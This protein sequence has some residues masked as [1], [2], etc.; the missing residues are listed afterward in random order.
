MKYHFRAKISGRL[1]TIQPSNGS[2]KTNRKRARV[3]VK[4]SQGG[5][6]M[7]YGNSNGKK[8]VKRGWNGTGGGK[9]EEGGD[10]IGSNGCPTGIFGKKMHLKSKKKKRQ[11]K[12]CRDT[13]KKN[14]RKRT[15]RNGPGREKMGRARRV[16]QKQTISKPGKRNVEARL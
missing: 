1:T 10:I 4:P 16:P 3:E 13:K 7:G 11:R 6:L 15:T 8:S 9:Q 5:V 14:K 2:K 12:G